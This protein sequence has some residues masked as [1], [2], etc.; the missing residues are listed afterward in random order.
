MGMEFRQLGQTSL[1]VSAVALGCWPIS[2]M[3]SLDVNE[4]DSLATIRACS[5]AGINLLDTA[6]CYGAD[7]E[8][9]RLIAR[10][11]AGRRHETVIATK[12]GLGWS[13]QL[14]QIRDASPAT[15]RR[16]C[17][18]SLRRLETDHVELLYL[19]APDPATP[20]QESAETLAKLM[21]EGKTLAVGA[22]NCS[23]EQLEEF[24]SVCPLSAVQPHYNMLQREIEND[25]LP[26]CRQRQISVCVYWPLLKGLLAGKLPRDFRFRP[27]DGRAKY[28]MFQ[29]EEWQRNQDLLDRLRPIAD[30][31]GVTLA[32]LVINWTVHQP[33]ITA[34]LCGAKRPAQLIENAG[35]MGWRLSAKQLAQI[36][37]ALALRGQPVSQAAVS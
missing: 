32:Q 23:V 33:G 24:V 9:E 5:D 19:H 16:Q 11:I 36:D 20:I 6:Y 25:L 17:E 35:G 1:Q 21:A 37:E 3:T 18:T 27:G 28:A 26:W 15:L 7:G 29:G 30:E 14:K 2:G 34:A 13:S 4:A 8:S 10:A 22:S 12:V 31:A